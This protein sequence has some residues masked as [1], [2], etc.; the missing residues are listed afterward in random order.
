M[1]PLIKLF[2]NNNKNHTK[3]HHSPSTEQ[4]HKEEWVWLRA[5]LWLIATWELATFK[6]DRVINTDWNWQDQSQTVTSTLQLTTWML[7]NQYEQIVSDSHSVKCYSLRDLLSSVCHLAWH[8]AHLHL[9]GNNTRLSTITPS[10]QGEGEEGSEQLYGDLHPIWLLLRL[11]YRRCLR[12]IMTWN[13][14]GPRGCV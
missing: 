11:A 4:L 14:L 10:K 12:S 1:D 9:F 3:G 6:S 7:T 2:I 13:A 5:P 8:L